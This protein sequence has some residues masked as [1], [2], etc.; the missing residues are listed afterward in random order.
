MRY[1]ISDMW[2][3]GKP[4]AWKVTELTDER[5]LIEK[6]WYDECWV[7]D[8]DSCGDE[9]LFFAFDTGKFFKLSYGWYMDYDPEWQ[10]HNYHE[11]EEVSKDKT[12][13]LVADRDWLVV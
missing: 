1:F 7:Y 2:S 10:I 3:N 11:I 6:Y 8:A 9:I 4:H 12:E 13:N 5:A